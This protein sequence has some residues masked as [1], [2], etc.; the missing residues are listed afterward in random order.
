MGVKPGTNPADSIYKERLPGEQA[1][2]DKGPAPQAQAPFSHQAPIPTACYIDGFNLYHAVAGLGRPVLK[3]TNL[4]SLAESY[5]RPW[6]S[7]RDVHLF[8]ALNTWDAGKRQRHV[9]YINAL[10]AYGVIVHRARFA[11]VSKYCRKHDWYC[12]FKEEKQSDVGMAVRALT[13]GFERGV[14]NFF[15]VTADSDQIPT[16]KQL[17]TSF[18]GSRIFLIVP[19]GRSGEARELAQSA[20]HTFDLSAGR[21]ADHPLPRSVTDSTGRTIATR[22]GHYSPDHQ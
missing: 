9:N 21:L 13:D 14:R 6:H 16:L 19:P 1:S 17:R 12:K 8:T 4:R 7:L 10:E 5:M 15:F 18:P 11:D 20:D 22:P 3:W 2:P